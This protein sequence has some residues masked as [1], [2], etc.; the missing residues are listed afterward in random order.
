MIKVTKK[1]ERL[2]RALL[3]LDLLNINFP[4]DRIQEKIDTCWPGLLNN[5]KTI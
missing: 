5:A 4:Q 2:A 1:D 3:T